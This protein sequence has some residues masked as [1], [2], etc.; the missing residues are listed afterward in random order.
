M[1]RRPTGY[2]RDHST[3]VFRA[4]AAPVHANERGVL[5]YAPEVRIPRD[6]H[7]GAT[8]TPRKDPLEN[9][10][11]MFIVAPSCRPAIIASENV[12][13]RYIQMYLQAGELFA[14]CFAANSFVSAMLDFLK[15]ATLYSASIFELTES[16]LRFLFLTPHTTQ[17][18]IVSVVVATA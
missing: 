7:R 11:G 3:V 13:T 10:L 17:D 18:E 2:A 12:V 5:S 1:G 15:F 16:L 9:V 4:A 8:K 6:Q 14:A